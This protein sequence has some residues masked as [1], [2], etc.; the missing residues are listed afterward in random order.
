MFV[1]LNVIVYS[2]NSP[3]LV[4]LAKFIQFWTVTLWLQQI[5]RPVIQFI[6]FWGVPF[7]ECQ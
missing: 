6:V 2:E 7:W 5:D 3:S 4:Y 1:L